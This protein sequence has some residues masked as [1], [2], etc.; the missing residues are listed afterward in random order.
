M[1]TRGLNKELV[2]LSIKLFTR[3]Y[4]VWRKE[5]SVSVERSLCAL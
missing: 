2:V 5:I 1:L 3:M 4:N